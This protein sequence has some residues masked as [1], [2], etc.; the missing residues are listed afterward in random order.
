MLHARLTP[1][2][3]DVDPETLSIDP[4]R[5]E[6]AATERAC[7]IMPVH[8][9]GKPAPMDEVWD[10]ATRRGLLVV[11]DAAEAHGAVYKGKNVGTK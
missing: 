5:I 11:E 8:L 3:V 1:V 7:A 2:F 4:S 9:M 10:I 6:N